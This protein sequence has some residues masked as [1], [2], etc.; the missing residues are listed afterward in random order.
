MHDDQAQ[1]TP[2]T[3]GHADQASH[4]HA[5]ALHSHT[6]PPPPYWAHPPHKA[7]L[8]RRIFVRIGAVI[9]IISVLMNLYLIGFV[10]AQMESGFDTNVI[11]QGEV[12]QTVAIYNVNGVID[13]KAADRFARFAGKISG[14]KD[15]KAVV[16]RVNSPGGGVSAS[17]Q[18]HHQIAQLKDKGKTVVISMGAVAASGGYYISAG[19]DEIV[20][21]PTTITGSI[22]AIMGWL[23]VRGTLEK[24]GIETVMIKSSHAQGWKDEISSLQLPDERQRKHLQ[25]ILDNIQ[26]TFEGVVRKG[27]GAKLNT[28]ESS[29]SMRVGLNDETR[30][31]DI[32]ETEPLNGKIYLADE[33]MELGLIDSK[34]YLGD[35]VDKAAELAGL[36]KP[37]VVRY[38]VRTGL[39]SQLVGNR[40]STAMELGVDVIDRLQTPR[41]MLMWKA[42]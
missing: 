22:G 40:R 34:G 41:I 36:G 28:R 42:N 31:I 11:R 27:R 15:V 26:D 39:L 12:K 8:C 5:A 13:S 33:A 2:E 1:P 4:E 3:P 19:A 25:S 30:E 32:T 18:I 21:E 20:A 10:A 14:D 35:A 7:S 24:I 29:Y 16:I 9:L 37:H 17:D 23:V 38:R 6:P